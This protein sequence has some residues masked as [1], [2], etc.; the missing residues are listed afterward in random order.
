MLVA[1]FRKHV[2]NGYCI[3]QSRLIA[4]ILISCFLLFT[5]AGMARGD[6]GVIEGRDLRFHHITS[7]D[8]L[9]HPIVNDILQDSTGFMWFGTQNGLNRYDGYEMTTYR[10]RSE[11]PYSLSNN[12]INV[13]LEDSQNELWV[14]TSGGGVHLYDQEG[15][16]FHR[17]MGDPEDWTT[18]SDNTIWDIYEDHRGNLWI[19]T[20]H[21]LN[22]LDRSDHSAKRFFHDSNDTT[23][24]SSDYISVL[25]EDSDGHFW[26]GTDNGLNRM[27][28]DNESFY[29]YQHDPDDPLSL[30]SNNV[31]A[32][33]EDRQGVLWIGT[34]NGLNRF[35]YEQ[36][37]FKRVEMPRDLFEITGYSVT[38]IFEDSNGLFWLGSE[39]MGFFI[40]DRQK[41][42]FSH[43]HYD[44]D[45][46]HTVNQGSV[47]A[48]YGSRDGIIWL[49]THAGG[50]SY[51]DPNIPNFPLYQEE[52]YNP[53]SLSSNLIRGF[54][55]DASGHIWI[56]TDGGGLNR[57]DPESDEFEVWHADSDDPNT[58]PSDLLLTLHLNQ[59]GLWMGSYSNGLSVLDLDEMSFR[60]FT[61]DPGDDR[62]LGHNDIF[63]I[64]EDSQG[65]LWLGTNGGGMNLLEQGSDEFRRF[66]EDPDDPESIGNN[67]VR[68]IYEDREGRIWIGSY[69][70]HV[71]RFD[72][73]GD[74]FLHYDIN[75][76]ESYYNSVIQ[77][78]HEDAQGRFWLASRGA[79]LIHF[80]PVNTQR[81]ASY[82]REDGLPGNLIHGILE[83][84]H[85]YLWLSTNHGISRFDPDE[86]IFQNYDDRAGVQMN[87]FY[88]GSRFQDSEGYMYFGG[89]MGF[90]RFHPDDIQPSDEEHR[91]LLTGFEIF[92]RP[93]PIGEDSPLDRQ[94]SLKDTLML[95]YEHSVITFW[96]SALNFS[97]AKGNRFAYKMEGFDSDWNFVGTRR[98]ATYTNLDPG[99]YRFMVRA[100]NNDGVWSDTP[101]E[102]V[103]IITP[104][105]WRTT[106]F[107]VSLLLFIGLVLIS[108]YRY[109]VHSIK[110][111]NMELQHQVAQQ[112][113]ELQESN[114]TKDKLLSIIAHDLNNS[115][116]GMLG[117]V[118]LLKESIEEKNTKEAWDYGDHLHNSIRYFHELLDNLLNWA[119]SQSG[120]IEQHPEEI[121][122]AEFIKKQVDQNSSRAINKNIN[123][124]SRV[125]PADEQMVYADKNMLSTVFRNLIH[126]A[127]KFTKEGGCI[128]LEA[129]E[130]G[131]F[132]EI[133]LSDEGVGMSD[134]QIQMILQSKEI[135]STVGTRNEK[136]TG[137]GLAL[138]RDF[139]LRNDGA[140]N[141]ESKEGEGST[142][143]IRLPQKPLNFSKLSQEKTFQHVD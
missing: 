128:T 137:L 101:S 98:T 100:T 40:Y 58:I 117:F 138:S 10:T 20:N 60:H 130:K 22:L 39:M 41:Q 124:E 72:R 108:A 118:E 112:T 15:D 14:G 64:H 105:F 48:I 13:I 122:L 88:G 62:S 4:R 95:S 59:D 111:R 24:I 67:F 120:K 25:F 19:A 143:I 80:D 75:Y 54:E 12:D 29:G 43:Y 78:F 79:G 115:I 42:T 69:L 8:G 27:D 28:R 142:F 129:R 107:I 50:V 49:G 106:W 132:V 52:V 127:I 81:V 11:D 103:L 89:F 133:L 56:A 45:D 18:L 6:A 86:E 126:N 123:L 16:R 26:I 21:G 140:L 109:R 119:R 90:N 37:H 33:Y 121:P 114:A 136:G 77:D 85:G 96:Y 73:E 66:A 9:S 44:P 92:N 134:E 74:R 97:A 131:D 51:L 23:S 94:I 135:K 57:F 30:S 2:R 116:F 17:I 65:N 5:S 87:D 71:T 70:G 125:D 102:L 38:E 35:D 32:I 113:A 7:T 104:P 1:V 110:L 61:H 84:D 31:Q 36:G 63:C 47:N 83:D 99:E 53:Q 139:I 93:V 91:V 68:A 34:D 3:L 46:P 141:I 82:T 76:G 55:E